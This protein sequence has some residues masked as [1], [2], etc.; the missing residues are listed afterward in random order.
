MDGILLFNKPILWTSHDAVDFIRKKIRQKSVGHAGT[1]DPLATGLLVMLI[2][3]ATKLSSVLTS[4]DKDY[5]GALTLGFSTDTQDLEGRVLFGGQPAFPDEARVHS[6]FAELTGN[7]LQ[8]PPAYSAVRQKGKKMYEL[9]RQGAVI[10]SQPREV[11]IS[12]FSIT[13]W[14][15]PEVYFFLT[16]SKGAYVRSLCDDVG[17]RLG[18]GATLS[19]LVRN[20]VGPFRLAHALTRERTDRLPCDLLERMLLNFDPVRNETVSRN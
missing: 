20:R 11:V 9:A 10:E 18:C 4:M 7:K 6:I 5:S 14:D 8:T 12:Q 2:G 15:P 3:K 1:L 13:R 17:K 19:A 16:C